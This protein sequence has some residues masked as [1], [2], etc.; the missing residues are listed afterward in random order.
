MNCTDSLDEDE[1]YIYLLR[2][3]DRIVIG[4]NVCDVI[5]IPDIDID[6]KI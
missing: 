1:V 2:R 4:N 5:V 3:D 6:T